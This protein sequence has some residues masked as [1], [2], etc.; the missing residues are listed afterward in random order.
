MANTVDIEVVADWQGLGGPLRMGLLSGQLVRGRETY[1]FSYDATWLE[2]GHVRQLDPRLLHVSGPQ[3]PLTK[4]PTFGVFLDSCPDWWG[5]VLLQR[6]EAARAR[7]ERRRVR[8]LR[9][10]DYLLGVFDAH[11]LGGLRF[12]TDAEGPFLD[13]DAAQASPPWAKLRELEA[14]SLRL[15]EKGIEDEPDY[16]RWLSQL[17]APGRSLGGARP[18][19]SVVGDDGELWIAKFPSRDDE[20]DVAAWEMV[21]HELARRAGISVAQARCERFGSAHHTFLSRRFD[22]QGGERLHMASAMTHLEV[23][24]GE[25]EGASYLQLA[26]VL[27]RHG[28]TPALDLEQLWRRIVFFVCISNVDDH[29][30]NHAFMLSPTGWRLAPAY[31]MNPVAWGDGLSLNISDVDNAQHLD[32]VCEV[33]PFFRVHDDRSA[34]IVAEVI[35]VVRGWRS[36]ATAW[37]LGREAQERMANAFRL[38][39]PPAPRR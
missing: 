25:A 33:A 14:L 5:R 10:W 15:E 26:E 11:R 29:L 3:F 19:A 16:L 18:K 39:E 28:A 35:D 22:R 12:R 30:R 20:E 38:A 17:V 9:E 34:A 24:D 23:S 21:A 32:L 27:I 37:G 31:D 8:Q 6:R 4:P 7:N 2:R 36:V 1:R 13:D